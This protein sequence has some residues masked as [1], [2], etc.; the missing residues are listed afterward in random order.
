M[1]LGCCITSTVYAATP[2]TSLTEA[3]TEASTEV[4]EETTETTTESSDTENSRLKEIRVLNNQFSNYDF[5]SQYSQEALEHLAG[6]RKYVL[7]LG[8]QNQNLQGLSQELS[9]LI[10]NNIISRNVQ[11]SAN[12]C[13]FVSTDYTKPITKTELYTALY[14]SYDGV[15][16]SRPYLFKNTDDSVWVL[17]SA[18]VYEL[19]LKKCLDLSY[20]RK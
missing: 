13:N 1:A 20:L 14:K 7:D 6:D 16:E 3:S 4:S 18:N 12:D 5:K 11:L 2:P 17:S 10:S 8:E 19:Y 9:W 15:L